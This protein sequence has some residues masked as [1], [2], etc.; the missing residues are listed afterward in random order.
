MGYY[1]SKMKVEYVFFNVCISQITF[2][3]QRCSNT[4]ISIS[5]TKLLIQAF[6]T[7]RTSSNDISLDQIQMLYGIAIVR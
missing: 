7:D 2:W 3:E 5:A 6:I 4:P 1:T